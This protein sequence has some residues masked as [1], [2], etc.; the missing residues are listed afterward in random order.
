MLAS[1][2]YNLPI[3]H[4]FGS[5]N[6]WKLEKADLGEHYRWANNDNMRRLVGGPPRPR[7]SHDIEA[8]FQSTLADSTRELYSVKT[9]TARLLGWVQIFSIDLINGSAE[10]GVV[11]EED[12]WGK[13]YG[14]DALAA[15]S[16]YA[17]EDLR[18][19][20]LGAEI[21]AIN[22]PSIKL[23]EKLGFQ[24][25]GVKRESYYTS[26][27]FLDIEIYGL[28]SRDYVRPQPKSPTED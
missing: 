18:L 9:A 11:I 26:G 27:R 5:V 7:S 20:R 25:E 17:F 3:M 19:H 1:G 13:G 2:S 4:S 6:L 8:W 24:K 15:V 28:L 21:L 10:V 14:H 22:L 16:T 23:F 12:E